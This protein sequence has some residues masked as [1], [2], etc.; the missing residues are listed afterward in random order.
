MEDSFNKALLSFY[1]ILVPNLTCFLFNH[2]IG[3]SICTPDLYV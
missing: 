3:F 1:L 2:L